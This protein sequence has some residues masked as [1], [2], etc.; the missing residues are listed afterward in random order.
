MGILRMP[1][2]PFLNASGMFVCIGIGC[3]DVFVFV[4]AWKASGVQ[5]GRDAP[6][7]HRLSFVLHRACGSMFI[8]S[9]TT[10]MAFM[11]NFTS[12]ITAL[13]CFGL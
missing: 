4:D 12:K 1:F 9:A 5:L 3:D 2:F 11:S 6:R 7:E 10:S 13:R 8:T